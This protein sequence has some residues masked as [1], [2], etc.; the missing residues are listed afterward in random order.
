MSEDRPNIVLVTVDSLRADHC[1]FMGYEED[2]TP[3]MDAM[4][5]D[6]LVLENAIAPGPASCLPRSP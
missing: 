1:G 3:T 5:E 2:T 6:G 4:A